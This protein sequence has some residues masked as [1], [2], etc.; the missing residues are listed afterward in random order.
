MK[1]AT[2]GLVG[3]SGCLRTAGANRISAW[4][5]AGTS[6]GTNAENGL[7]AHGFS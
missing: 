4:R 1:Q 6:M 5:N 7:E 2:G 3:K